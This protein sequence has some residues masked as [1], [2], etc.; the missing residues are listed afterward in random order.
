MPSINRLFKLEGWLPFA[1]LLG[2]L[3]LGLIAAFVLPSVLQFLEVD[4]CLDEGGKYNYETS[5][6]MKDESR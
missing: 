5:Q 6:C 4:R 3:A 2:M 1:V